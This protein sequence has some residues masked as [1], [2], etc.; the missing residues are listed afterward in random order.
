MIANRWIEQGYNAGLVLHSVGLASSTY[1]GHR[2]RQAKKTLLGS[3]DGSKPLKS[4][5]GRRIRGYSYTCTGQKVS[6]EQIKEFIMEEI[7]GDGYPYG[8]KKLTASMQEDYQLNINHKKVYRLCKEL[9]VLLPQRKVKPKHPRRLAKRTKV[10]GSNQLWQMDLKYGYIASI[11]RF[12]FIISIIDVYDRCIVGYHIG[13]HALALDAL[14]TLRQAMILRGITEPDQLILRTDNG[15]Q[16]TA[17][18]FQDGCAELAIN[19]T[20]IPNNTPNMNAHIESFHSILES[21]CLSRH[22]FQ[23]Y[24]EAYKC[25]SEFMEYY[26]HRRRHGSLKNQAP[27]VF[28]HSNVDGELRPA[29][30]VA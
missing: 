12:F 13:L 29:M 28:Y 19:H 23:S 14:R 22:E 20:R 30:M 10:T 24:A 27:M 11:D 5:A 6:D 17:H 21:D 16:F 26:N 18:A 8:Y 9:D 4:R 2:A 1:Y 15:P 7:S 3:D 25:V